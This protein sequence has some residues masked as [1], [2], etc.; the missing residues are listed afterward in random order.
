MRHLSRLPTGAALAAFGALGLAI[1]AAFDWFRLDVAHECLPQAWTCFGPTPAEA[2]VL[3]KRFPSPPYPTNALDGLG[4]PV[5]AAL[6]LVVLAGLVAATVRR[7]RRL[8]AGA[9]AVAIAGAAAIAV[10]TITQPNIG[11]P[12]EPN[13]LVDVTPAAWIGVGFAVVTAVG[14]ALVWRDTRRTAA[15]P[16]LS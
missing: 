14:A 8:L 5:G 2:A 6:V 1:A 7:R 15:A 11:R 10:R 12:Y 9:A 16:R 13:R 3:A 4:L